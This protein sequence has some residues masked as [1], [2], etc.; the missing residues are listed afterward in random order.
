MIS[1]RLI[2]ALRDTPD[3]SPEGLKRV[4]SELGLPISMWQA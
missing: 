3:R 1:E 2:P 4:A